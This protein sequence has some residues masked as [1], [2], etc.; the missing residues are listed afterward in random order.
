MTLPTKINTNF[1]SMKEIV[2]K[3]YGK[4]WNYRGRYLAIKGGRG[5][6]KSKTMALRWMKMLQQYENANLLVIR[7]VFKDLRDSAFADLEWAAHQLDVHNEWNFKVSPLEIVNNIT[8]QKILFRGLDKPMS[9]TSITV[10]KGQL[11]WCWMEE[12]YQIHSEDA[13][14]KIDMSIRGRT[15]VFKQIVVTL[16]PWNDKHW[17]K[18]RFFDVE[19]EDILA[20]TT[21]Y[22]CNEFLDE[23]DLKLF[24]WMKE[25]RPRRYRIEGEGH[26]GISEGVIFD[27]WR[28]E[29]F[30]HQEIA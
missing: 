11:C 7:Q 14:D 26:W 19:D 20:L 8:G 4:A 17:I 16:N 15:D 29:D 22:E 5:S 18:R 10:T 13:F 27:N 2:G 28:V 3:G 9:V 30:N 24:R 23:A 25:N 12:A 6:K 21:T 1:R